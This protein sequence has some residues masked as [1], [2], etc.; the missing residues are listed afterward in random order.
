M[1]S[2]R[3]FILLVMLVILAVV[4]ITMEPEAQEVEECASLVE[5]PVAVVVLDYFSLLYVVLPVEEWYSYET[6]YEYEHRE[7]DEDLDDELYPFATI[8]IINAEGEHSDTLLLIGHDSYYI[9]L[10]C[11]LVQVIEP[12][13]SGSS[14]L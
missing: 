11:G 1:R 14:P 10:E 3:I 5:D 9:A 2:L 6:Y 4:V 8:L 7:V 12:E 13:E